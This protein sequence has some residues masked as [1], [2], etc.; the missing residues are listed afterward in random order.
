MKKFVVIAVFLSLAVMSTNVFA[1]QAIPAQVK[2]FNIGNTVCPV[3][4]EEIESM[5]KAYE[6][7]YH[8]KIYNLCCR[9]CAKDFKKDPEKYAGIAEAQAL[10]VK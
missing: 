5:G 2:S 10:E 8:G 3:S 7:E 4:G 9:Q 6:V 1:N